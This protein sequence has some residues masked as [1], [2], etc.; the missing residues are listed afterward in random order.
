MSFKPYESCRDSGVDGLGVIP[1]HWT[2]CHLKRV[3]RLT[4]GEAL[5]SERRD[6]LGEV[7]VFGSNGPVGRHN[8]A[9]TGAP[10]IFVGRKGSNGAL[11]WSDH[12]GF[13]IDTVYF[14]DARSSAAHLRWLYW[15]LHTLRLD[16]LSQ[17]T[18]VPG[19]ARELAHA[20][21]MA[22]PSTAEQ[23]AI[24]AFLDRETA[25]I[26]GLVEEQRRLIEL[27]KEKRQAVIS[28]TVTRGLCP[29]ATMKHSGV[30]WLGEVPA[31][32]SVKPLAKLCRPDTTITYGIIQAGPDIEGGIPYIRTSDMSGESLPLAGYLRTSAQIDAAYSRSKVQAGDLVI[33]IRATIGKPLV[34]PPRLDGANLT[35]G[36]ARFSPGPECLGE[37][38][39]YC[40]VT[41]GAEGEFE[42]LGKGATF[43][44]ITLEMLRKF[45]IPCPPV[46]EQDA[47]V[48]AVARATQRVDDLVRSVARSIELLQER[49]SALI[50]AAVTGKID[51]RGVGAEAVAA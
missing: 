4:Y 37:Y 17:D 25:K 51:V 29:N 43:K 11:N 21:S 16:S 6:D 45:R 49:R 15:A 38:V 41:R 14:I 13:G 44:E 28:H 40:L 31:H 8:E 35:Q 39:R 34:V 23:L 46:A 32:W 24:A 2:T 26:D 22:V 12:A 30:E 47:I 3:A 5:P 9:N 18:G 42:R 10:V 48:R 33:A 36:T 1:S 19:L 7:E 27:L 50:S 20:T